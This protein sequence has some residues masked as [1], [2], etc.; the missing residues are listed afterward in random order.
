MADLFRLGVQTDLIWKGT[1][2]RN[3]AFRKGKEKGWVD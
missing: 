2:A 3:T 1:G